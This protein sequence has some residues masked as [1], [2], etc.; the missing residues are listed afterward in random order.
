MGTGMTT[1]DLA[2]Y[3]VKSVL[4]TTPEALAW[5]AIVGMCAWRVRGL[6]LGFIF[7]AAAM[8]CVATLPWLGFPFIT[9]AMVDGAFS[10]ETYGYISMSLSASSSLCDTLTWIF[11]G[12]A[13]A[14]RRSDVG[15][16]SIAG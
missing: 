16:P 12:L 5:L 8:W 4:M 11:L 2:W 3:L 13:L 14:F 15:I 6:S 1:P 7:A 10:G 9:K